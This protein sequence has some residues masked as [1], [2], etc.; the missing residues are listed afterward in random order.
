MTDLR[1]RPSAT[2]ADLAFEGSDLE[3][4]EGLRPAVLV[5][6][7]QDARAEPE[8][9]LPGGPGGDRRGWWGDPEGARSL[10]SRLWLLSR[11]AITA[12]TEVRVRDAVREG[13]AWILEDEIAAALEVTTERVA[14][15]LIRVVVRITR[16][17]SPRWGHLWDAT[18]DY[19]L[20][21]S[22]LRLSF[23]F[24]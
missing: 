7:F 11:S 14:E 15:E 3:L 9:E 8:D 21:G 10:G 24:R 18:D 16:G 20:A 19:Q 6:L 12:E 23:L 5:S 1:L 22:G 4:D 13:L 2:G 17:D